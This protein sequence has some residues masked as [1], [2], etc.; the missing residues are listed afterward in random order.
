MVKVSALQRCR[1][2]DTLLQ[3]GIQWRASSSPSAIPAG[4]VVT[5]FVDQIIARGG[6]LYRQ[7][8]F[9]CGFGTDPS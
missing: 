6:A 8:T 4:E 9:L 7:V 3:V 2:F 1:D 5:E